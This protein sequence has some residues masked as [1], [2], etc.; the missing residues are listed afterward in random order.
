MTDRWTRR[1][2]KASRGSRSLSSASS[3]TGDGTLKLYFKKEYTR[4]DNLSKLEA[5]PGA[6]R[7]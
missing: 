1:R 2:T 5:P 6:E 4:F 3:A 7:G